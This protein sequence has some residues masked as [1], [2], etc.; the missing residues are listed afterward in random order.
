MQGSIDNVGEPSRCVGVGAMGWICIQRLS[1]SLECA[2]LIWI[3]PD[4]LVRPYPSSQLAGLIGI[5]EE[6]GTVSFRS[7]EKRRC[8]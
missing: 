8:G 5:A 1:Y 2:H 7:R 4:A 6:N 3:N